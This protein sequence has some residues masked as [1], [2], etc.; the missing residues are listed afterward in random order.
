[1]DLSERNNAFIVGNRIY[2]ERNMTDDASRIETLNFGVVFPKR[3]FMYLRLSFSFPS[4][5]I[6]KVFTF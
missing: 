1:M 6:Y 5:C 2:T 4:T 3:G